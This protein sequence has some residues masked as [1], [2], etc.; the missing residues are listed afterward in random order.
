VA[1]L[2]SRSDVV[3]RYGCP[4]GSLCSEIDK[5]D[6]A[7]EFAA[8]SLMRVPIDWAE[9]QFRSLGRDDAHDLA[10]DLLVAYEGGALLANTMRDPSLLTEVARRVDRRIDA[11]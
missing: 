3:A 7:S 5:R 10:V 4:L 2:A 8:A 6:E 9:T 11:L 1:E